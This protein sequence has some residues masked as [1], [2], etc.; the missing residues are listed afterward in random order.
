MKKLPQMLDTSS[1]SENRRTSKVLLSIRT[2]LREHS[3]TNIAVQSN[4]SK[5]PSIHFLK[6]LAKVSIL[7]NFS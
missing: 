2:Y 7:I 3:S 4:Q 6:D 5:S 1:S